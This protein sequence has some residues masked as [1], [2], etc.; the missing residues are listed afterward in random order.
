MKQLD[1]L[2]VCDYREHTA[3]TVSGH[4]DALAGFPNHWRPICWV[5]VRFGCMGKATTA[6]FR[7]ALVCR[8]GAYQRPG[9]GQSNLD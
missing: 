7:G 2:L 3:E 5:C 9:K 4:I 6:L 1:M 8:S